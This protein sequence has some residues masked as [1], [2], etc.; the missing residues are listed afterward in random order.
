MFAREQKLFAAIPMDPQYLQEPLFE[1]SNEESTKVHQHE[2]AEEDPSLVVVRSSK[3][4]NI[5]PCSF[6]LGLM[7]A[8]FALSAHVLTLAMFDDDAD[9]GRVN[10]FSRIIRLFTSVIITFGFI[11]ASDG[12]VYHLLGDPFEE[13]KRILI[14]RI[15]CRYGFGTLI[16]VCAF[17]VLMDLWI[18]M[19][20][21]I[22]YNAGILVGVMM[23]SRVY[24]TIISG[25]ECRFGLGTLIGVCSAWVL[26]NILRGMDGY[27]KY[28]AGMLVGL[29]IVSLIF[30]FWCS[31]NKH[32]QVTC[33]GSLVLANNVAPTLPSAN[34]HGRPWCGEVNSDTFLIA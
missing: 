25:L 6:L 21:H 26:I 9:P 3:L 18:G 5:Q 16:G 8:F 4:A 14:W 12:F 32:R 22:K 7:I 15:K 17:W 19:D 10:L 23:L 31:G 2:K 29:M 1:K 11:R 27:I 33:F 13:N 30:Q 28:S 20:G 34:K 24:K